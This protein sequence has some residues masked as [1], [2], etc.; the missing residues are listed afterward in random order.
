MTL[1]TFCPDWSTSPSS[2]PLAGFS[3]PNLS[4]PVGYPFPTL[5]LSKPPRAIRRTSTKPLG[6]GS[7]GPASRTVARSCQCPLST[8]N[9]LFATNDVVRNYHGSYLSLNGN[10]GSLGIRRNILDW[11]VRFAWNSS[12]SWFNLWWFDM[13]T[14]VPAI[15]WGVG[16]P[17]E[18]IFDNCIDQLV[19]V[20]KF[21]WQ[22]LDAKLQLPPSGRVDNACLA[23]AF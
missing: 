8:E 21:L 7:L 6:K 12:C 1:C 17:K 16:T 14:I 15:P 13:M 10:P 5:D 2:S 22:W 9:R 19:L 18:F 4:S 11:V 20:K 23:S 3:L